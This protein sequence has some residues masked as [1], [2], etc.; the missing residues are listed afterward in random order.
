MRGEEEKKERGE[1]EKKKEEKTG[2]QIA[3]EMSVRVFFLC[4]VV[5]FRSI[6]NMLFRVMPTVST[7]IFMQYIMDEQIR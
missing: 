4:A 5:I 3:K 2:D 7:F 6:R 1:K